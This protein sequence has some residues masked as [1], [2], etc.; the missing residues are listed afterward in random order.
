M[1][2][3]TMPFAVVP[4]DQAGCQLA[5]YIILLLPTH[6]P[7]LSVASIPFRTVMSPLALLRDTTFYFSPLLTVAVAA[8][9]FLFLA[10]YI[11][12]VTF[13]PLAS[14]PGPRLAALT[15]LYG[16]SYDLHPN[17]SY[18]KQL[19][20]LHDRYGLTNVRVTNDSY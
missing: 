4:I 6:L 20:A 18:C 3:E 9:T 7:F 17:R 13:H 19:P 14:F 1:I 2:M 16:A 8:F 11:Y 15:S 5:F 12:R 10:K